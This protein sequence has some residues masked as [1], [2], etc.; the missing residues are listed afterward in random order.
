MKPLKFVIKLALTT[1]LFLILAGCGQDDGQ[2]DSANLLVY[3]HGMD[4]APNTLD[5]AQ[6]AIIYANFGV[7]NL[8]DTLYRYKYL[9]R[10]YE[11]TTNL[12][13][14]MPEISDDGL[15]YTIQI[16]PGVHY[17]D[18][19]AFE[20]GIGREV[21]AEDFVYALKRHFDPKTLAQGAWI[22]QNR[23]EGLDDWAD[24][25]YDYDAPVAGL[26][27]L[28]KYT[29][30]IKLLKPY[31]QL[32]HTFA[33]GFSAFIPREAVEFYGREISIHPVG[34]GPFRLVSFS[35]A[36]SVMV[37]NEKFRQEP[38]DLE[39][40]G[41]D[42]AVHGFADVQK[43]AGKSPPFVDRLEHHYISEDA[44]R[45]NAFI[46][47]ELDF[48]RAPANQFDSVLA[49]RKPLQAL[50][51]ISERFNMLA[52][53]ESGVVHI[54]FNLDDERIGYHDDPQQNERNHA[55]RC[56]I[57]KAFDFGARNEAIYYDIARVYAG[58]IPPA[59]PEFDPS[60]DQSSVIRD[61]DGAKALLA[62]NG[63]TP[64]NLPDLEYGFTAGVTQR[65]MYEQFRSFMGD[66]GY[67][68]DKIR[69]KSYATFG[70][71]NKAYKERKVMII[72]TGW[73]MDYPDA[74]N[75]MQLFYGPNEAPGSNNSNM[76]NE[77]FD[78]LYEQ[79]AVMLPSDE[80]T[81][82]YRRMNEIIVDECV[83]ITGISRTFVFLWDKEMA[84]YPDRSFV[85][86][87]FHRFVAPVAEAQ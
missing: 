49:S 64:E 71:F 68:P 37:R 65:Q 72:P 14:D 63:W 25:G 8:Y 73:N 15:T 76:Q 55:L 26:Q 23:I 6:A 75:V 7:I 1:T 79:T 61:V 11:L 58:I 36:R 46:S 56:S 17:I 81:A 83:S 16:K 74:E 48:I 53:M 9:A 27:A 47:G 19:E 4:G 30:Q 87:Y 32:V 13:V 41:Y 33:M 12:A 70:D 44:A 39:K 43:L 67:H 77:E 40:E 20:G 2:D 24:T 84:M 78:G 62:L 45:W 59:S 18:D 52:P 28:D 51:E 57:I 10:P 85:S 21:I 50:P 35:S 34:S 60:A 22:W 5:P 66:I 31:P 29:I 54:D 42:E 69:A 82:M 80:R 86:G 38:F 3:R